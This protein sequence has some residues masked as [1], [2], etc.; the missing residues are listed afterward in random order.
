MST[1]QTE[2]AKRIENKIRIKKTTESEK[3]I[4]REGMDRGNNDDKH[5][6]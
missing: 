6:E 1:T 4:S 3:R 2:I 5:H